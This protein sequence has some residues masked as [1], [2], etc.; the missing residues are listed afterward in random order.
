VPSFG[1]LPAIALGEW[2]PGGSLYSALSRFAGGKVRRVVPRR[3]ASLRVVTGAAVAVAIAAAVGVAATLGGSSRAPTRRASLPA[4]YY[5]SLGDSLSQGVQPDSA[6]ASVPTRQGYADLLYVEL[7]RGDPGLR[8]V[9]LG[10]SGETTHTMING[11]ICAYASRSQLNAA[12]GFLRAHRGRVSLITIDIG[13][14][15]PDSC[16]TRSS[17]G[18]AAACMTTSFSDTLSNLRKIMTTLRA[19]G[20]T[21]VRIIGMSY[22]VP[23]L[24]QWRDGLLGQALARIS[25]AVVVGYNRLLTGVYQAFGARV[26]DVFGAFHSGEFSGQVT[27]R[28]IGSVPPNVAAICQLTWECASGPR[29]PNEHA[30]AAGYNV[31]AQAFR[32]ADLG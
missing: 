7:R 12:A 18:L 19:A 24:A 2:R 11:G 8:L 6:G 21:R 29:G 17:L 28:G 10:C 4:T 31:I 27:V 14:N 23:T 15:D 9:K 20:G 30:T 25:E 3:A 22:Y 16:V 1:H 5:L 26:A 13:A 32:R